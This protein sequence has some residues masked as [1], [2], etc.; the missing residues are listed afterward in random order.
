VSEKIWIYWAFAGSFDY[1]NTLV[2]VHER[3][4]ITPGAADAGEL[5][6]KNQMLTV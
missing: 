3:T 2:M 5:L 1:G 6:A 4:W